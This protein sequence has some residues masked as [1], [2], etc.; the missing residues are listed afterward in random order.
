MVPEYRCVPVGLRLPVQMY[1]EA[2]LLPQAFFRLMKKPTWK[3]CTTYT[4]ERN[5]PTPQSLRLAPIRIS[6]YTLF[7]PKLGAEV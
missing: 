4:F 5:A 1:R 2:S 7:K 6:S 3:L